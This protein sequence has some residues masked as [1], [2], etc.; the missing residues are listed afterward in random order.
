MNEPSL[1]LLS[2]SPLSCQVRGGWSGH[3]ASRWTPHLCQ[4]LARHRSGACPGSVAAL[5]TGRMLELAGQITD[6]TSAGSCAARPSPGAHRPHHHAAAARA[7]R[8]TASTGPCASRR[9]RHHATIQPA[10]PRPRQ[11]AM[12]ELRANYHPALHRE[13]VSVGRELILAGSP[14]DISKGLPVRRAG[15]TD[16]R[17]VISACTERNGSTRSC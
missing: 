3:A 13:G 9:L 6:G 1:G 10:H 16:L 14:D 12:Y 17:I 15:T 11:S 2:S 7:C 5:G 8:S 4:G